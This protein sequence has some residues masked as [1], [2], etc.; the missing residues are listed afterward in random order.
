[1]QTTLRTLCLF[2]LAFAFF[3]DSSAQTRDLPR[4]RTWE[5]LDDNEVYL[6]DM[7]GRAPQF[8]INSL[9][10]SHGIVHHAHQILEDSTRAA[11][12]R[13]LIRKAHEN[14]L[15]V[16]IWT[17]EFEN[18][19]ERFVHQNRLMFDEPE[20]WTWLKDK[21]R[22]VFQALPQLDGLVLT[23]SETDFRPNDAS[24]VMSQLSPEE[25]LARVANTLYE[26]C[27]SAGKTL[28]VR[29]FMQRPDQMTGLQEAIGKMHPDIVIMSKCVPFDWN[30]HFPDNPLLGAVAPHAQIVE[31]DLGQEYNGQ[32][33]FPY[34]DPG[35][36]L[37]RWRTAL[38]RGAVGFVLRT[39]RFQN[40]A[41]GTPNEVNLYAFSM[42][43][44]NPAVSADSVWQRWATARY[45]ARAAEAVI[46]ALKR[47]APA[48]R[49][50]LYIKGMWAADQS[51]I[52]TPE[53]F[54]DFVALYR[55][56]A[57]LQPRQDYVEF[58]S[59]LDAP[60]D[61]LLAVA[62]AEKDSAIALAKEAL[63]R[64]GSA[65]QDLRE[66]DYVDL[67]TRLIFLLDYAVLFREHTEVLLRSYM[68]QRRPDM[69][70]RNRRQLAM[71]VQR[72]LR[73]G[74]LFKSTLLCMNMEK[75]TELDN[76]SRLQRSLR[77]LAAQV[78][79]ERW[80][81]IQL[82]RLQR[83]MRRTRN[84][85]EGVVVPMLT[86]FTP[87]NRLDEAALEAFTN[88]LC[89]KETDVLFPMGGSGE[90]TALTPEERRRIINIV[91]RTAAGRRLVYPGVGGA[92]LRETLELAHYAEQQGADGVAVV[93]PDFVSPVADSVV[94]YLA[95]VANAV[96]LPVMVYDPRGEGPLAMTPDRMERL[97]GLAPNVR[98]IK[99]RAMDMA[100]FWEMTYRH[101]DRLSVLAGSEAVLLPALAAGGRGVV[102]GGGNLYPQ[103]LR[104]VIDSF[105]AGNLPPARAAQRQVLYWLS[106]LDGV[107]WPLSGK[108]ALQ[109]LGV[110]F[111][112]VYRGEVQSVSEQQIQKIRAAFAPL[113]EK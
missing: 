9:Q 75:G 54:R 91:V 107:P 52:P 22:A 43:L 102:G 70:G 30:P 4:W 105:L 27:R 58:A 63:R 66:S 23:M 31:F 110:P 51:Q 5:L 11:R 74:L 18:V 68:E 62:L 55:L 39:E 10:L 15:A 96:D 1:M 49:K 72:L 50:M 94:A 108:I 101:G 111:A 26:V 19:P 92:S 60:G 81:D 86:P 65:R 93:V 29:T 76:F 73:A 8:G 17:H 112:T 16:F 46:Q 45:G 104:Q 99:F 67:S 37:R 53:S 59:L 14:G 42:V 98:A 3:A 103:H 40:H 80:L 48:V 34:C 56:F 25:R 61:S 88:W 28:I 78:G 109:A 69:E 41:M 12:V 21:Y 87:D 7:I 38:S 44:Q 33:Y 47:T 36:Y 79:Q 90:Y 13:R 6:Q 77:M 32:S 95:R 35:Y 71:A 24:R 84:R 57:Q 106:R 113:A 82:A 89:N 85:P 83:E 20:L 2:A 97:L 100:V 64:V